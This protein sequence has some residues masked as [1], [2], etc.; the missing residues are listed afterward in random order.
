MKIMKIIQIHMRLTKIK[1]NRNSFEN[2]E[3]HENQKKSYEDH[4][5]HK[6]VKKQIENHVNHEINCKFT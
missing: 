3:N 5:N 2:L 1:N 6:N 4:E